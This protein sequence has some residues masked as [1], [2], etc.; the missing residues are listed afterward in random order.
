MLNLTQYQSVCILSAV[1]WF[2]RQVYVFNEAVV[3]EGI[4]PSLVGLFAD[5]AATQD[6]IVC[7]VIC[8]AVISV[9][10]IILVIV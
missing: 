7:I 2:D 4:R 5:V 6:N 8:S 3:Q 1:V 9:V 10:V